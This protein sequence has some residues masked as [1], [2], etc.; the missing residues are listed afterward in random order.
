MRL[1]IHWWLGLNRRVWPAMAMRPVSFCA[2]RTRSA[3][4]TLS[5]IGI[6]TCTCLPARR[7]CMDWSACICVGRGENRG[8]DARLRQALGQIAGPVRNAE[9][10]GHL[11]GLLLD[12]RR[13]A[14][15]PARPR[16][17]GSA[18]RCLIP[19]APCPATTI[20]ITLAMCIPANACSRESGVPAPCSTRARDR[21][22]RLPSRRAPG[23]HARS[24][25]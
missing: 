18:S 10:P 25:T 23:R 21:S 8:L 19:K 4:A 24:A 20:L 6:S 17:S 16:S 13:R 2:F 1:W 3:S 22:D 9:L 11:L 12:C 5:D 7:H 14:R 15:R